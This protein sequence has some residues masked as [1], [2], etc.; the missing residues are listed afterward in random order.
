ML[1]A[2][3]AD[4]EAELSR[5]EKIRPPRFVSFNMELEPYSYRKAYALEVLNDINLNYFESEMISK[6]FTVGKNELIFTGKRL[7]C[8]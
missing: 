6:L 5:P 8:V 3:V 2:A 7:I 4:M 1:S